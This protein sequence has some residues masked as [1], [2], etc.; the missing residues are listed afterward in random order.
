MK[1]TKL[2]N[3]QAWNSEL[4]IKLKNELILLFIIII[5]MYEKDGYTYIYLYKW[6][7]REFKNKLFHI[8]VHVK[9][10]QSCPILGLISK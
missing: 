2:V 8:D 9:S 3:S 7:R 1:K 4:S 10:L 5:Y 6:N